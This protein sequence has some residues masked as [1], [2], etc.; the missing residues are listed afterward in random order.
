MGSAHTCKICGSARFLMVTYRARAG[1]CPAMECVS[2]GALALSEKAVPSEKDRE[3]VRR[4]IA[5]REKMMA[6]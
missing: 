1:A 2:C 3:A 4:M 6:T 5:E